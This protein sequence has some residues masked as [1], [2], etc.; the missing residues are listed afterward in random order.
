MTNQVTAAMERTPVANRS[1]REKLLAAV[2]ELRALGYWA[3]EAQRDG[4]KALPEDVL[5]RGGKFMLTDE[6]ESAKFDE[7]DNLHGTLHVHHASKDATEIATLLRRHG[8]DAE[9]TRVGDV[10]EVVIWADKV[11]GQRRAQPFV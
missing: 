7:H 1:D 2:L 8:L 3:R 10:E 5:K 4:I 6:R 11:G 9:I